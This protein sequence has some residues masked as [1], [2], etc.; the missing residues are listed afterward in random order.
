MPTVRS[1]AIAFASGEPLPREALFFATGQHPQSSLAIT[2]GCTLNR[3]GTV[4]TGALCDTNVPGCSSPATRR[5]T[6]SSSSSPPSEGMKAA[7]AINKALQ[8]RG[9]R[10]VSLNAG[11]DAQPI[12]QPPADAVRRSRRAM[13]VDIRSVALTI[14]AVLAIV[15]VLQYAQAMIIPIVL[16]VL[17]SYAL[18][19]MV[20]WFERRRIPRA[21]RRRRWSLVD[22]GRR[23]AGGCSTA[24]AGRPARS[25]NS[26][27][28]AARR[29]RQ[30]GRERIG[31]RRRTAIQQVQKAATELEKAA[32]A[33][34]PPPAPSGVQR[35][36]VEAAPINISDYLMWGSLGIVAALG[37]ARADSVPRLL[38]ARRP[39]ICTAASW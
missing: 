10:A 33:A 36:Q 20:A 38:P 3:R 6:R 28:T 13:P 19:P 17:I 23:R 4:K 8:L 32:N 31:R 7:V 29:L 24:S 34:S 30:I 12:R 2:L 15:L 39:A 11:V 5:A 14:L 22:A 26:C 16:G 18:E 27:R 35:V 1:A 37:P 21:A 9:A 25:S